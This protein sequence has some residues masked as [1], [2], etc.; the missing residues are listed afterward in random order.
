MVTALR[1]RND[2]AVGPVAGAVQHRHVTPRQAGAARQQ[3]GLVGLDREQVVR[4]L[5]GDQEL[6]GIVVS[7]QR[8]G[9]PFGDRGDRPRPGQHRSDRQA[10]DRDQ[11][12]ATA[13]GSSRVGDAGQVG[14]QVRGFGVLELAGIGVGELGERGWDRG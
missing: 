5:A 4:L 2:A 14:Q 11:W 9:G 12:V 8:V 6:G 1:V 10:Q 13:T 7:L 3:G